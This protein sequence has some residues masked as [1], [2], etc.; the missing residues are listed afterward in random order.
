MPKD[1]ARPR[2][3][4]IR[5]VLRRAKIAITR[6]LQALDGPYRGVYASFDAARAAAPP[7]TPIGYDIR[8]AAEIYR[9]EV[10]NVRTSD[11]P[12][13]YWLEKAFPSITR[14]FD[15]GGN[16]GH[17]FYAYR[18]YLAYPSELRWTICDVPEVVR[19]GARLAIEW[20]ANGLTF[21]ERPEACD[22][23]DV[24]LLNGS[25]QYIPTSLETF[26]ATLDAPPKH[27]FVNRIPVHRERGFYTLQ[28][29]GPT[30]CP[31]RVF[32][33]SA[34]LDGLRRCGYVV[35]DRWPC[36]GKSVRIPWHPGATV[37]AYTGLYLER[38]GGA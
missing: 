4:D 37:E 24:L 31:Y 3:R 21:T 22:G 38:A 5:A 36:E 30:V 13:I 16:L 35:R 29:I 27:V 17:S 14:V 19:A 10:R 12:V 6:H 23:A 15:W 33:E 18:P 20:N 25:L 1:E 26:L 8:E 7:G 32:R 2:G 28:N 34:L 11:Y 9:H